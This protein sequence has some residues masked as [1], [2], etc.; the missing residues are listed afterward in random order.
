MHMY[1]YMCICIYICVYVC[2]CMYMHEY[3]CAHVLRVP[4]FQC[5]WAVY[6]MMCALNLEVG[7]WL[8]WFLSSTRRKL[9]GLGGQWMVLQ[10]LPAGGLSSRTSAWPPPWK[11]GMHLQTRLKSSSGQMDFG[12]GRAFSSQPSL[13]ISQ[14]QIPT[15][16]ILL[17]AASCASVPRISCM[18]LMITTPSML[19]PSSGRCLLLQMGS[20]IE[21]LGLFSIGMDL[22]GPRSALKQHMKSRGKHS[23]ARTLCP[24]LCGE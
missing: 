23:T 7:W 12:A 2:I 5:R 16:V 11:D 20:W 24:T 19:M 13:L 9:S 10:A 17:S 18:R 6:T 14:R 1:V 8:A 22:Y 15:A 3:D 4:F 21:L